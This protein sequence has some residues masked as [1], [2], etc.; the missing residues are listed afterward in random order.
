MELNSEYFMISTGIGN[1]DYIRLVDILNNIE[2]KFI[3]IDVAN[4]YMTN[5]RR[6]Y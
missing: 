2:V 5:I 1:N 4:G 6:F 3:C